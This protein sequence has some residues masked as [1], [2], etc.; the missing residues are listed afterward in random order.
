MWC[1]TAAYDVFRVPRH[2]F[3]VTAIQKGILLPNLAAAPRL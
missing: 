3:S 2:T 1:R